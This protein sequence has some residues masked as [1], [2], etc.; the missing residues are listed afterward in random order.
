MQVP[1]E[2]VLFLKLLQKWGCVVTILRF[3]KKNFYFKTAGTK[4]KFRRS[5]EYPICM[6][7][8]GK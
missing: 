1:G 3:K 2:D 8:L 7:C 6:E 4:M 5:R